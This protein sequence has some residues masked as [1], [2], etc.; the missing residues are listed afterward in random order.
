[1]KQLSRH[2]R[3]WL[4][5]SDDAW[6]EKWL[7]EPHVNEKD[8]KEKKEKKEIK[9]REKVRKQ[10]EKEREKVRKQEEKE[11]KQEEKK[12]KKE[13]KSRKKTAPENLQLAASVD[14]CET[15]KELNDVFAKGN[16]EGVVDNSECQVVYIIRGKFKGKYAYIIDKD[17]WDTLWFIEFASSKQRYLVQPDEVIYYVP[18]PAGILEWRFW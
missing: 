12:E 14:I 9:A 3:T 5:Q 16:P 10:E 13:K 18:S 15:T 2:L 6:M 7:E 4:N 11:R 8:E 1:M 17:T